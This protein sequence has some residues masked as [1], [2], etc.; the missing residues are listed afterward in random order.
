MDIEDLETLCRKD[1]T[2]FYQ[3]LGFFPREI[4]LGFVIKNP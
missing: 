3:K 1:I 4:A 2:Q